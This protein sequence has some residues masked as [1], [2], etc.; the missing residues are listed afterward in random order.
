M[1]GQSPRRGKLGKIYNSSHR[2][3]WLITF[4]K[5]RYSA[6]HHVSTTPMSVKK[7]SSTRCVCV[8]LIQVWKLRVSRKSE[9]QINDEISRSLHNTIA[10]SRIKRIHSQWKRWTN[11]AMKIAKLVNL[12][13]SV[14]NWAEEKFLLESERF[15][16]MPK[17]NWPKHIVLKA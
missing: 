10:P 7:S 15:S 6:K 12:T 3:G 4:R 11:E 16:I 14:L 1:G 17:C 9:R 2:V 8:C 5:C 13:H